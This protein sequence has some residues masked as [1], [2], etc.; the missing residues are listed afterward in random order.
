M[1]I[2]RRHG[3]G[4][5]LRCRL[6]T[7]RSVSGQAR[8]KTKQL[9]SHR[10]ARLLVPFFDTLLHGAAADASLLQRRDVQERPRLGGQLVDTLEHARLREKN[11]RQD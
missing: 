2:Q 10:A 7:E 6:V 5:R 3:S 1:F 8:M 11:L 9:P 4:R